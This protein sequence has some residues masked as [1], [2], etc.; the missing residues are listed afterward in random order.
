MTRVP[1]QRPSDSAIQAFLE[2]AHEEYPTRWEIA[3][4]LVDPPI[5]ET[6]SSRASRRRGNYLLCPSSVATRGGVRLGDEEDAFRDIEPAPGPPYHQ[7]VISED[8][9]SRAGQP[10]MG[11]LVRELV[12]VGK[13]IILG[14]NS[15]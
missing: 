4:G 12:I 11:L 2:T 10:T 14:D 7:V 15:W 6:A 9:A 1:Y 8:F 5:P 13:L 3:T